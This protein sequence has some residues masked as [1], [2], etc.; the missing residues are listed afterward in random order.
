MGKAT[1]RRSA[2]AV[3]IALAFASI[4]TFLGDDAHTSMVR[5]GDFPGFFV[6]GEILR[7]GLGANLYNFSLQNEIESNFWPNFNGAF[8]AAVYPPYFALFMV[9]FALLGPTV[10][11]IAFTTLMSFLYLLAFKNISRINSSLKDTYVEWA[12]I[13]LLFTPIFSS[14]FAAQNTALSMWI[15]SELLMFIRDGNTPT[16]HGIKNALWLLK[17]QFGIVAFIVGLFSPKRAAYLCGYLA[18]AI[19]L[20]IIGVWVVDGSYGGILWPSVW[21]KIAGSFGEQNFISNRSNMISLASMLKEIDLLDL[22]LL[23]LIVTLTVKGLLS[24]RSTLLTRAIAMIAL[25]PVVAPQTLFYDLGISY[26]SL[27]CVLNFQKRSNLALLALLYVLGALGFVLRAGPYDNPFSMVSV[28]LFAIL[29]RELISS[30]F[31][32]EKLA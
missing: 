28:V 9:P 10:G 15:A 29:I 8:Y 22:L 24:P 11:Q 26:L 6:Q 27:A 7:R 25:I 14:I 20:Y 31:D 4:F 30:G 21:I 2:I 17:P 23:G 32:S 3:A 12:I 19:V 1:V 16:A 18:G 13:S 5:S